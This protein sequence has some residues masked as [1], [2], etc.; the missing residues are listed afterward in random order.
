MWVWSLGR[1]WVSNKSCPSRRRQLVRW[2]VGGDRAWGEKGTG[3]APEILCLLPSWALQYP[4]KGSYWSNPLE[5]KGTGMMPFIGVG[6]PWNT[7]QSVKGQRI[8]LRAK[9][10]IWRTISPYL[11]CFSFWVWL[12]NLRGDLTSH[13]FDCVPAKWAFLPK[14]L[15]WCL[16]CAATKLKQARP[17][18]VPT[19]NP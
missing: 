8:D 7:N 15:G 4:A 14:R 9:E 17:P 13:S 5:G 11:Q 12:P 19:L 16:I 18:S 3:R 1:E 10:S 6:L 2:G